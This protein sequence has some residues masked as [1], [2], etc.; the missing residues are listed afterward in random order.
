MMGRAEGP[1]RDEGL[2]GRQQTHDGANPAD[3]QGFLPGHIRKNGRQPLP[4]TIMKMAKLFN[5]A[6]ASLFINP[7]YPEDYVPYDPYEG[8]K[9][10]EKEESL[11]PVRLSLRLSQQ[12]QEFA[13]HLRQLLL[14]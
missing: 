1:R 5:V 8:M 7:K 13:R 4:E 6:P 11:I 10:E 12:Q 2:L 14:Q 3:L 9:K